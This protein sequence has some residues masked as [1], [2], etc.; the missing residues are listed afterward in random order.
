VTL[1][2]SETKGNQNQTGLK[3]FKPKINLNHN[4]Y[5]FNTK[6]A[7]FANPISRIVQGLV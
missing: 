1:K 7:K 3:N 2:T 4:I 6:K 5:K